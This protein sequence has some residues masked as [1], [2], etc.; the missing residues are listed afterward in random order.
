MIAGVEH[1]S[2]ERSIPVQAAGDAGTA[3]GEIGAAFEAFHSEQ[4]GF[5]R[6]QQR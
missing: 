1:Q 4:I 6:Q 5:I 3:G 2:F